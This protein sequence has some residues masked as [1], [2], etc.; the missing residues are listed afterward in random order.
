MLLCTEHTRLLGPISPGHSF[1]YDF[2]VSLLTSFHIPVLLT[3]FL[4][5][6]PGQSGTYW[7]HS[8]LGN[9]YCDG[10]RGAFVIYDP[11]DPHRSL[12]DVDNGMYPPLAR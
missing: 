3:Y 4:A 8:H 6:A 10:L 5:K 9:Q 7:Y 2:K 12:Y 11:Q 1:L